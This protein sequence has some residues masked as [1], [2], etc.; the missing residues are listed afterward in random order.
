M[1]FVSEFL[2]KPVTD[3]N[4]DRLGRLED[5][6][7][8]RREGQTHPVVSAL[9][10]ARRGRQHLVPM[11]EVAILVPPAIPLLR[12]AGELVAYQPG[13]QDLF[14]ARDVLDK[15]IID[16]NGVRV[17][18]VNDLELTRVNHHYFVANV[19]IGG[20]GLLRR[21]G[22]ARLAQRT[23]SLFGRK[24]APTTIAW[25]DVEFLPGDQPMRLKVPG[26]RIAE[27]HPA[28]L[29]EILS[30]LTRPVSDKLLATLD[31]KTL[32]DTL[33]EVEP[34]FQASLIEALPDEKVADVLEEMAPDEAAD[35]L[36]EL[37]ESRSQELL[38]MM[39]RDEAEDVRRLLAYPEDTAGGIM[40]TEFISLRP[41]L[42]AG[43]A[44]ARLRQIASQ[45]E[46]LT[47]IYITQADGRLVGVLSLS[48]L[49][50]TEPDTPVNRLMHRR[51]V[52][53]PLN[54]SQTEVAQ[55]IAKYNLVALPV[56]DEHQRIQGIVTADDALDKIIPTS[57]K[58]RLPRLYH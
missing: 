29:A 33:E 24:L 20:L 52:S 54:A 41:D 16:T 58:K 49:V 14:L 17:V 47:Y 3:A 35:L 46:T 7:A 42:T 15:Q 23:A 39:E 9:V 28:D 32:A 18:R 4:G 44:L 26:E 34:D 2:A 30:D 13:D 19:D 50:L 57:W 21:L 40:T 38:D 8:T 10:V 25:T 1:P 31:V 36:A 6:I 27:L 37:P 53:V 51:I 43:Q 11:A 45:A 12:P 55:A 22:L 5:L 56:V 48:E